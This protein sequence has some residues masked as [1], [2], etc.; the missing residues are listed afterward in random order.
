MALVETGFRAETSGSLGAVETPT[1]GTLNYVVE[2][3]IVRMV[4]LL[5]SW[6][7]LVVQQVTVAMC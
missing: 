3:S 5:V 4:L 7:Y 1:S 6:F 2:R